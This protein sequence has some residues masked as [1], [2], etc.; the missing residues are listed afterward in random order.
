M[1]KKAITKRKSKLKAVPLDNQDKA[2][3]RSIGLVNKRM[4]KTLGLSVK[5]FG[6]IKDPDVLLPAWRKVAAED[7]GLDEVPEDFSEADYRSMITYHF[8]ITILL[9]AKL[10]LNLRRE[11]KRYVDVL[12]EIKKGFPRRTRQPGEDVKTALKML[13]EG[14][15]RPAIYPKAIQGFDKMTPAVRAEAKKK[16]R[17]KIRAI[18]A[19]RAI[20]KN[21]A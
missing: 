3:Q 11:M 13:D 19:V 8:G 9:S 10:P 6:K 5:E 4:A 18:Q 15:S 2:F 21:K 12:N 20:R 1:I 7:Y 14:F 17:S 16:L